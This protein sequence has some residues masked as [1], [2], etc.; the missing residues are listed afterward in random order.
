MASADRTGARGWGS[1][2]RNLT[3]VGIFASL[4]LCQSTDFDSPRDL[5][6]KDIEV[7]NDITK[8]I[9]ME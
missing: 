4:V 9:P 8:K 7:G 2:E 3:S 5:T 6:G 1:L